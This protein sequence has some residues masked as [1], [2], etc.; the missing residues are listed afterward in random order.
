MNVEIEKHHFQIFTALS[1]NMIVVEHRK[2]ISRDICTS[3]DS[4]EYLCRTHKHT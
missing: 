2:R 4:M 3:R 1:V